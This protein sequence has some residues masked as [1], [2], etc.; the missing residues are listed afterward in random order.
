MPDLI[1]HETFIAAATPGLSLY[2][3]EKHPAGMTRFSPARTLLFVH[4]A[5]Y[6]AETAFDLALDGFSWM[7]F[8]ARRGFDVFL[9]D[10]RGYGRS[11]R[12]PAMDAPPEANPPFATTADARADVAAAVAHIRAR[13]G[14]DR[15]CLLG[16]SW[17][18]ATMASF[19]AEHPGLVERLVLFAPG[20]LR[21]G[22]SAADPGGALGCWRGVTREAARARWLN[23]V[24]EAKRDWLIPPE[25]FDLWAEATFAT[26]PAGAAMTPPVL[27]A[28]NGVVQDGRAF[29]SAGRPL[30]DPARI[31]APT[32]I[33]VGEWD[34][35]T[36]P[37]LGLALFSRLTHAPEKRLVLLGEATHTA[38]LERNRPALF[39]QVQLFLEG[40][41][42]RDAMVG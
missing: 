8:I 22:A 25:W 6:P 21:E 36:P 34:R 26:D 41:T 17:G 3:R 4:G 42:F 10:V 28:P 1:T 38:L 16:W 40:G 18:C 39:A 9:V 11:T 24:P 37:A 13:R 29:W 23:G 7:D 15:L 31:T 19:A 14:I 2:V 35:D 12:P 27:R 30:Y 20:W 5:T 33:A 32:M